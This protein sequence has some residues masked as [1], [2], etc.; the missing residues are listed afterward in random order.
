ME[1]AASN[2]AKFVPK[3]QAVLLQVLVERCLALHERLSENTL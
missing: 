3:T 2:N 1:E